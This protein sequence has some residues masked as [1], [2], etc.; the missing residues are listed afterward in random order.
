MFQLLLLAHTGTNVRIKYN[1][2][3]RIMRFQLSFPLGSQPQP[4][5]TW[6][7]FGICRNAVG[8]FVLI[9]LKIFTRLL[10]RFRTKTI[11]TNPF[12][13]FVRNKT[14]SFPRKGVIA[15]SY[16]KDACY[17]ST[18]TPFASFAY[19]NNLGLIFLV[20]TIRGCSRASAEGNENAEFF[21]VHSYYSSCE[22]F[23]NWISS[24]AAVGKPVVQIRVWAQFNFK[25]WIKI[26]YGWRQ[27]SG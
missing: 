10:A 16:F 19:G 9:P 25:L 24:T 8:F 1:K 27:F 4:R 15:L 22:S 7:F 23:F 14:R 3:T 17:S 5:K 6:F 20:E 26:I 18:C 12:F 13:C 2:I 11:Y 21:L